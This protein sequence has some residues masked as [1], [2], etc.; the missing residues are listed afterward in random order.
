MLTDREQEVKN[1]LM[2]Y[3]GGPASYVRPKKALGYIDPDY[4]RITANRMLV[5]KRRAIIFVVLY[6]CILFTAVAVMVTATDSYKVVLWGAVAT[7]NGVNAAIH[8]AEYQ[9]KR[10]AM[11][12]F[13]L[14][15]DDEEGEA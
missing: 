2:D 7:F 15:N 5:N 6:A 12:V 1:A 10:L 9:K 4:L 13:D 8:Y 14:L 3:V 11:E